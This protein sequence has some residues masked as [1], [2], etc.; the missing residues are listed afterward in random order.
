[1]DQRD[2]TAERGKHLAIALVAAAVVLLQVTLTRVLSVLV[3]YHWAFFSISLAMLGVGAPGVWFALRPPRPTTLAN[4]LL[5][6]S[7]LVPAGVALIVGVSPWFGPYAIIFSLLALLPAFLCLGA[8]VCVLLLDAPGEAVGRRYAF[9]L[10]GAC[11]GALLVVPL[12]TVVPTPQ[13]CAGLGLVPLVAMVLVHPSRRWLALAVGLLLTVVVGS[14]QLYQ[15]H[16]TKQYLEVGP[17]LTPVWLKWTPTARLAVFDNLIPPGGEHGFRWGVGSKGLDV[18][19]P[20]QYW[21]EQDGS[22]GTPITRF[23][24]DLGKLGY[25]L[26]D[27]TSV[28]YQTTHPERVAIVGAGGGRDILTAKLAGARSIDAIELNGAIVAALRGPFADF[29]GGVYDLDGVHA[30]VGEGRSVLTRSDGGYDLIQ[31]SMI[32]SWAAT[33]AG[34][35]ALSENNLYT[36]EA[37]RL[38]FSRLSERGMV[39]TSR[40]MPAA[41][42]GFEIVRLMVLVK[43]ALEAEGVAAPLEHMALVQGGAVGTVLMSRLP[44]DAPRL[45]ELSRLCAERGFLLVYPGGGGKL[46]A[47]A[48]ESPRLTVGQTE[49]RLDAPTD[50]SPF[51]FQALSPLSRVDPDFAGRLGFNAQSVLTLQQ[52]MA[53]LA[54]VT[55]VTFFAPFALRRWLGRGAGF[56][57]GSLYFTAIGLAFMLVEVAWLGRFVL[58]LGHPS[59][60]TTVTL[61][62]MLLGAGLGS[63]QS[64]RLGVERLRRFGLLAAV[65]VVVLNASFAGI[66]AASIGWAWPLRV[67][68]AVLL[69]T[70]PAFGMGLFFPLGMVRF[71]DRSKA[72]FWALNGAAGVLASVLSLALAM[73]WG[74]SAVAYLG[75][76][77]YV[78]AWASLR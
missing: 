6:S 18:A 36:L 47:Q 58:Y 9:D 26:F 72:W 16:H 1:M 39:A 17:K 46:L 37:Y 25:L 31:I 5:A 2:R 74:F 53:V 22:A 70:P 56:W 24:G 19:A 30:I 34:A 62:A 32:D 33:A 43:T 63:M 10:L 68:V 14:G 51:F 75:A 59:Y 60:A 55:L 21:L 57:R 48:L 38:Y 3:W 23:D 28:G 27:V 12:L 8:A 50:D 44:F 64:A 11:V 78:V 76:A 7:L 65:L 67:V 49:L 13:L 61:G 29:S 77:S 4:L 40:W 20:Q 42:F 35:F 45:G 71:G 52:L 15:L 54:L 73:H 41:A 66:F 69:L